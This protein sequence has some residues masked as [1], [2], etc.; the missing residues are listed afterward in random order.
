MVP[1]EQVGDLGGLSAVGTEKATQD[2]RSS[3]LSR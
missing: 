3:P 2:A 1:L